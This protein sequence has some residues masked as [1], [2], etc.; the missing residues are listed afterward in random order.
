MAIVVKKPK[1]ST[2]E[3]MYLEDIICNQLTIISFSLRNI[4]VGHNEKETAMKAVTKIA[5]T[6]RGLKED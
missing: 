3:V 5:E 2:E 4:Q 6:I 1:L